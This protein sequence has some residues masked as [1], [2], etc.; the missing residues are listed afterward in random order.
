MTNFKEQRISIKLGKNTS[1][2]HEMPATA[3]GDNTMRS[4]KHD[5]S[6]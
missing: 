5:E 4:R 2:M 6:L 3:F 1:E